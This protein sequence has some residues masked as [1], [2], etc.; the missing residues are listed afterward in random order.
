LVPMDQKEERFL[1]DETLYTFQV[2]ILMSPEIL[3]TM[4]YR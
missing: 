3:I 4:V 1:P 2:C